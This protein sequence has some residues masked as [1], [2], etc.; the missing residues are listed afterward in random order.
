[1]KRRKNPEEV[2]KNIN[3]TKVY[4]EQQHTNNTLAVG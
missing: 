3:R 4:Q 1:M 2:K